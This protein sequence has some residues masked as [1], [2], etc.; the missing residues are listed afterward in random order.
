LDIVDQMRD[1]RAQDAIVSAEELDEIETIRRLQN[2]DGGAPRDVQQPSSKVRLT[3][4][5]QQIEV[6]PDQL[7]KLAQMNG[8]ADSYLQEAR[9][10]LDSTRGSQL[11]AQQISRTI[12]TESYEVLRK[13]W[14]QTFGYGLPRRH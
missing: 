7:L 13:V 12:S 10:V 8:A 11:L 1:K 9:S 4:R 6:D 5:G 14:A 2:E 3:I